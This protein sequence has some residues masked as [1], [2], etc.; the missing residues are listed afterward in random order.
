M[1]NG[2]FISIAATTYGQEPFRNNFINVGKKAIRVGPVYGLVLQYLVPFQFLVMF[3]WWMYQAA[4]VYDPDEWWNP[5][6]VYSVGTCLF[7]WG[8]AFCF[9]YAIGL[10][11]N[12]NLR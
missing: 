5:V 8:L 6:R 9:L 3:G 2:L 7:Q 1:I 12:K 10:R 11:A 4:T